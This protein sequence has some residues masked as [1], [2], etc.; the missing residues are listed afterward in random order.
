MRDDFHYPPD[1]AY[2]LSHSIGVQP[3]AVDAALEEHFMAPWRRAEGDAWDY[4]LKALADFRKALAPLIGADA[5]DICQ[6]T[7]ISSALSKCVFSLPERDKR[8]K[9]VLTE[10]DFPTIGHVLAQTQRLGYELVFLPGG[11][12]L[13][14]I[15]GWEPAFRDD[16]HLLHVTHVFS[17]S[18]L[19]PPVGD[20]IKR[21]REAGVY[22][23]LDVAQSAGAVPVDLNAWRPT[24]AT[25]TS[26]K[27]LCGGPGA[28]FLWA[29]PDTI[30][31]CKPIDV[32]WFSQ[33]NPFPS[34]IH[35]FDYASDAARFMGG[36]PA[37]APFVC[38]AAAFKTLQKIGVDTIFQHNQLLLTRLIE[39]LPPARVASHTD[40]NAR[41]SS[42]IVTADDLNATSKALTKAGFAHDQRM[43]GMR[44]SV[45]TYTSEEEID[46]LVAALA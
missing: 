30:A 10:E 17:N 36:T 13:A 31:E 32:G 25:G 23:V 37:V 34:H 7:N 44:F 28:A 39:A 21:A 22:T 42:L 9:I 41:G 38:A 12:A 14:D 19:R 6:Q 43:G 16:V 4:W 24:F 8:T 29:N 33:D 3:K 1:K 26:V 2:F 20:I 40:R 45:H 35:S 5:R 27:Y 46:A 15:S 11:E 18:A